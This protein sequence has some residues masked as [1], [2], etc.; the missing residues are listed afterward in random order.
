MRLK[1]SNNFAIARGVFPGQ[2]QPGFQPR[3]H[4]SK[5]RQEVIPSCQSGAI[6][7]RVHMDDSKTKTEDEAIAEMHTNMWTWDDLARDYLSHEN[8]IAHLRAELEAARKVADAAVAVEIAHNAFLHCIE[9][10]LRVIYNGVVMPLPGDAGRE[11]EAL[12]F[13]AEYWARVSLDE[14]VREYRQRSKK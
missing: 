10:Q 11:I 7:E 1:R 3:A 12:L 14:A 8:Q 13:E 4:A 6:P 2:T 5:W 9:D